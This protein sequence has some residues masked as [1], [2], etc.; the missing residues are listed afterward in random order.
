M[1]AGDNLLR[2]AVEN[3][4]NALKE[5][6]TTGISLDPVFTQNMLK[7]I[8][9]AYEAAASKEVMIPILSIKLGISFLFSGSNKP[10][11]F[12]FL[13]NNKN[14]SKSFPLPDLAIFKT[15]N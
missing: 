12:N 8:A 7:A 4:I 9:K 2:L 6:N 15:F 11:D 10:S 5:K 13:L 1:E 3:F 14:L